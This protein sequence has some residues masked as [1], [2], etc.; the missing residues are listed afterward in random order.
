MGGI[1]GNV[2]VVDVA[3]ACIRLG[4][5]VFRAQGTGYGRR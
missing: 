2:M 3:W 4:V 5:T 1:I